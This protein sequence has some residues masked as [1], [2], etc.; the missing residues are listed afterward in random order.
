MPVLWENIQGQNHLERSHEEKA[1]S[2][3]KR[4]KPWLRSLL[5]HQLPGM[6]TCRF[7]RF[8]SEVNSQQEIT[9]SCCCDVAGVGED[10]GGGAVWG[11]QGALW[12]WR[13]V[14]PLYFYSGHI[15][16]F[17]LLPDILPSLQWLVRL[18]GSSCVCR[19]SVLCEG[20]RNNGEIVH[21]HGGIWC[22]W[23]KLCAWKSIWHFYAFSLITWFVFIQE[24][25][26]F[27]LH[28]LKTDLSK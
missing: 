10:M 25:H 17:I 11:W 20:S 2:T 3:N 12:G 24:T 26:E 8:S 28:K 19:V 5:C 16:S 14:R 23:T 15:F 27:D 7:V 4:Q 13:W 18:A 1:A 21:T 6:T 9:L 22:C